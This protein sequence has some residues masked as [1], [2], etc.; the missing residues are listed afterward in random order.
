M[1]IEEL[2]LHVERIEQR[3][4]SNTHRIDTLEKERCELNATLTRMATAVEILANEQKHTSN[5]Q[6]E[7]NEKIDEID[8]KVS[9]IE[10]APAKKAETIHT[11]II[12]TICSTIIGAILGAI[13]TLIFI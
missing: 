2:A 1:T 4:K 8:A 3:E 7:A 9:K 12:K 13:L 10:L 6:K 11:E 5:A